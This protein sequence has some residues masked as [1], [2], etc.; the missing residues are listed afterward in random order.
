MPEHH[1]TILIV[2]FAGG[3]A[4]SVVLA[5]RDRLVYSEAISRARFVRE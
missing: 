1:E 5:I 3:L 2:D 4:R